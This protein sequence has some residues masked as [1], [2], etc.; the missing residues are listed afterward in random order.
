MHRIGRTG[1]SGKTGLATTFVNRTSSQQILL[2]LKHL[3]REAK[4]KIPAFLESVVDPNEGDAPGE[5][6]FCGGLGHRI[7]DCPKLDHQQRLKMAQTRHN[8][9]EKNNDF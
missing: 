6:M 7:G 8:E 5:C 2:D 3:L 1:R 4:Q 9:G